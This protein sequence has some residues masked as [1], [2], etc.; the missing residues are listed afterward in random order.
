MTQT[1]IKKILKDIGLFH[2]DDG[3]FY[4]YTLRGEIEIEFGERMSIINLNCT[5]YYDP[6]KF[7]KNHQ[8]LFRI[9]DYYF[10]NTERYE[11][12]KTSYLRSEKL[13]LIL[14]NQ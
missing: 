6:P 10:K 3:G 14:E 2:T 11:S 5:S 12:V 13:K 4:A 7:P 1:D 9:L 8:E